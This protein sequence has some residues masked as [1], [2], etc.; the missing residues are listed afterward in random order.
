MIYQAKFW[1]M[2]NRIFIFLTGFYIAAWILSPKFGY[3]QQYQWLGLPNSPN[4]VGSG[5]RALGMGGAFIG[6]ADD[7][8]AASWNPGG[9][10]QLKKTELSV[11]GALLYRSETNEFKAY[12]EASGRQGISET[13]IN[14]FSFA[15]PFNLF[16]RNMIISLNYQHLFDF[17]R[18]WH[19]P[20]TY[21]SGEQRIHYQQKGG[22]SAVG[23]AYCIQ[24]T[25]EFSLGVTLN[26]WKNRWS[27]NGWEQIE[28][29]TRLSDGTQFFTG[30]RYMFEGFNANLGMLW[31]INSKLAVGAV[32]KT[33][34]TADLK[35]EVTKFSP[36]EYYKPSENETLDMPMSYGIGLA[37]RFSDNLTVS[38]DIYR[39][40]W[41]DFVL[42]DSMGYDISLVTGLPV[43]KSDIDPTCQIRI[44]AEYLFIK[45]KYIIPLRCGFF[46]DPAPAQERPDD[47][48][49]FSLGSGIS[50]RSY[51]FD[52]AY[53]YR[54][55]NNVGKSAL[56]HMNFS[57]DIEEHTFYASIIYHF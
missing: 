53:Q 14:Y 15:H 13:D 1:E 9:L 20:L 23:I 57:Q 47:F 25:P 6:V 38:G 45:E 36:G 51:V 48:F 42:T 49:G 55:G 21:S 30:N 32:F 31:N 10:I 56:Q 43:K 39:T 44:G 28:H 8:T 2:K 50:I 24:V 19:F 7:A 37:Y 34:F 18:E 22:L 16:R 35:H 5:A 46:Y 41:Q 3:T 27:K 52:F 11:V 40:E 4:P 54:F 12:P 17:N 26:V 29:R 33:P